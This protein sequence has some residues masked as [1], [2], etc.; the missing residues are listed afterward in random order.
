MKSKI[1]GTTFVHTDDYVGSVTI[2]GAGGAKITVPVEDV[3]LFAA[4]QRERIRLQFE[5]LPDVEVRGEAPSEPIFWVGTQWSVTTYGVE[6][7]NGACVIEKHRLW[8]DVGGG[9]WEQHMSEKTWV[10]MSDLRE[11]LS[12]ARAMFAHLEP[13]PVAG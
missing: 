2:Q 13:K 3:L 11:A 6:A 9:G 10:D 12:T 4:Q 1:G 5:D 8:E 7:R